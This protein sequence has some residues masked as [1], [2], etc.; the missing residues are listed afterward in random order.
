MVERIFSQ[1]KEDLL[2]RV[3]N[4]E[5]DADDPISDGLMNLYWMFPISPVHWVKFY[6]TGEDEK[7][8]WEYVD[9]DKKE[10]QKRERN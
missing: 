4:A 2:E 8:I 10:A 6:T 3:K 5:K 7:E 9:E 1:S